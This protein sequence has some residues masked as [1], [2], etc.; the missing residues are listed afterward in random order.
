MECAFVFVGLAVVGLLI[1]PGGVGSKGTPIM[2][3]NTMFS[4]HQYSIATTV[5]FSGCTYGV[6]LYYTPSNVEDLALMVNMQ[7]LFLTAA[8]FSLM[9]VLASAIWIVSQP[10]QKLK[11]VFS[12]ILGLKAVLYISLLGKN[13]WKYWFA[14]TRV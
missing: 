7:K 9:L 2:A 6:A 10:C 8:T 4:A 11:Y 12:A 1:P 14:K 5:L 3:N 13:L